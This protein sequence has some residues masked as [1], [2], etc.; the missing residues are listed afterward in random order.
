MRCFQPFGPLLIRFCIVD[1]QL[2]GRWVG[3]KKRWVCILMSETSDRNM[4]GSQQPED[5]NAALV[6][7]DG[8]VFWGPGGGAPSLPANDTTG[9]VSFNTA[10]TGYQ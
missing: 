1:Y 7:D 10:P 2:S 3:H 6:L 8:T 5:C 9:E 4:L